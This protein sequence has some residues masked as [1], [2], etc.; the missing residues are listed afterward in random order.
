[1]IISAI[2]LDQHADIYEAMTN[3]QTHHAGSETFYTGHHPELD[4]IV[5]FQNGASDS[6]TLIEIGKFSR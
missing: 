6:A 4:T 1:M 2:T 3:R 5:I